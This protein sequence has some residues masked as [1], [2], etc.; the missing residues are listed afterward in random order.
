MILAGALA[1]GSTGCTAAVL[2]NAD[3]NP[4][5]LVA[6]PFAVIVDAIAAAPA[7][8]MGAPISATPPPPPQGR[9][10]NWKDPDDWVAECAG[11]AICQDYEYAVC[12][13]TPGDCMCSCTSAPPPGNLN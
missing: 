9:Y 13:G 12:R 11:P 2:Q 7:A 6:L 3:S 5:A 10:R 4:A 8:A 1:L